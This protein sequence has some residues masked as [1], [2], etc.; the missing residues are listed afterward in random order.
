MFILFET[1]A[2]SMLM[3]AAPDDLAQRVDAATVAVSI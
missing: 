1:Q 2:R 3:V